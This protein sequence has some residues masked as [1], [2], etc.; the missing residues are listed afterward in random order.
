[1]AFLGIAIL[2]LVSAIFESRGASVTL[3]DKDFYSPPCPDNIITSLRKGCLL[4]LRLFKVDLRGILSECL[5]ASLPCL[6]HISQ[7]L[8][9]VTIIKV[10]LFVLVQK[11]LWFIAQVFHCESRHWDGTSGLSFGVHIIIRSLYGLGCGCKK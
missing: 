11:R 7:I 9:P 6:L 3:F 1:M 5:K 8:M 4:L 10:V 2:L